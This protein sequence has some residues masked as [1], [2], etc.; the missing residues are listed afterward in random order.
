MMLMIA[1]MIIMMIAMMIAIMMSL[2]LVSF[3]VM[4]QELMMLLMITMTIIMMIVMIDMMI[5]LP[6][7]VIEIMQ[8]LMML[9]MIIAIMKRN[10]KPENS[11]RCCRWLDGFDDYDKKFDG[12]RFHCVSKSVRDHCQYKGKCRVA[13]HSIYNLRYK[14]IK[15][16]TI[17]DNLR[18]KGNP[19]IWVETPKNI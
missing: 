2:M 5:L 8:N 6:G 13:L 4:L 17:Q 9:V 3:I 15:D 11:W 14:T 12:M 10:L 1:I 18:Y 19:N 7:N 16:K